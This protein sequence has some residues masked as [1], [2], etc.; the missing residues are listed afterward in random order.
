[1]N[2][3]SDVKQCIVIVVVLC[4]YVV[5]VN[6]GVFGFES[7]SRNVRKQFFFETNLIISKYLHDWLFFAS[8]LLGYHTNINL[9][10]DYS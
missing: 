1:M 6:E 8:F 7:S 10:S 2:V 5:L 9:N 3:N 4:V